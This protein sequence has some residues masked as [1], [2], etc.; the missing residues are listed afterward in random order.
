MYF[1]YVVNGGGCCRG[2]EVLKGILEMDEGTTLG[3]SIRT[4]HRL[5]LKLGQRQSGE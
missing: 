2:L 3:Y 4:H 5:T 1:V